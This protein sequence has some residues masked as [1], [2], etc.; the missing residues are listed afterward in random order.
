MLLFY[1]NQLVYEIF[2]LM[3]VYYLKLYFI[4]QEDKP[5]F[6]NLKAYK[7]NSLDQLQDNEEPLTHNEISQQIQNNNA[8]N[9]QTDEIKAI[10]QN[11]QKILTNMEI[12]AQNQKDAI[13]LNKLK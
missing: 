1:Q 8:F 6:R 5:R 12:D 2:Y 11:I 9:H 13:L 7:V 3:F 4:I 10:N